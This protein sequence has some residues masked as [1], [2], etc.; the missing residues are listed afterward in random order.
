MWMVLKAMGLDQ[1]AMRVRGEKG[2][3]QELGIPTSR[4]KGGTCQQN[5]KQ[6]AREE[7]RRKTSRVLSW[8]QVKEVF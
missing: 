7:G 8:R 6:V 5:R 4:R 2:K 1:M 3:T